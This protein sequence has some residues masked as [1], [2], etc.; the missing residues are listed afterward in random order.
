MYHGQDTLVAGCKPADIYAGK[1]P[2][3]ILS[4]QN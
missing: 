2:A 4:P 3:L 1:M